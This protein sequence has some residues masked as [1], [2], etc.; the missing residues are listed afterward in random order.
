MTSAAVGH[1]RAVRPAN[2]AL[3]GDFDRLAIAGPGAERFGDQTLVV[4]GIRLIQTVGVGRVEQRCTGSQSGM[5]DGDATAR[6]AW[7]Y[8]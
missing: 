6:I 1:P 3:G 5:D 8:R 4:T 2:A 7:C